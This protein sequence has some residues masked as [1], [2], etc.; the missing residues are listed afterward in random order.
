MAEL[1]AVPPS[2]PS[3]LPGG[4]PVQIMLPQPLQ[5][6][7]QQFPEVKKRVEALEQR[8]LAFKNPNLLLVGVMAAC[9]GA[10]LM[11]LA[12]FWWHYGSRL[13]LC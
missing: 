8:P 1:T 13:T 9:L 7:M 5:D 2:V 3:P 6:V 4:Q 12:V 10:G 11:A